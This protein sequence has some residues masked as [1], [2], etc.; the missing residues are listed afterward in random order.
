MNDWI[1]TQFKIEYWLRPF[2]VCITPLKGWSV[3][4]WLFYSI[5]NRFIVD[6]SKVYTNLWYQWCHL[7]MQNV[8]GI[9]FELFS[10]THWEIRSHLQLRYLNFSSKLIDLPNLYFKNVLEAQHY[11]KKLKILECFNQSQQGLALFSANKSTNSIWQCTWGFWILWLI[12]G[13]A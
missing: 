7:L 5:K 13:P 4:I 12:S 6:L 1:K 8:L 2:Y 9:L 11:I 3:Q 10:S